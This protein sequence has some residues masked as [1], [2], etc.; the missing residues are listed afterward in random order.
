ML[1]CGNERERPGDTRIEKG[2][3]ADARGLAQL[4]GECRT[5]HLIHEKCIILIRFTY[6][7][8]ISVAID[9]GQAYGLLCIHVAAF[10]RSIPIVVLLPVLLTVEFCQRLYSFSTRVR[11]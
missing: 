8:I 9:Y 11:F 3:L 6:N 5:A 1:G 10:A 7:V 2:V 4:Q